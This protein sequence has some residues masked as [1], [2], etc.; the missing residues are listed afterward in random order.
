MAD[1]IALPQW[2]EASDCQIEA[3]DLGTIKTVLTQKGV[4]ARGWRLY[5]DHGDVL[6]SPLVRHWF[7]TYGSSQ[8]AT[9]ATNWLRLLQACEMDVL[10][11]PELVASI[12]QWRLPGDRLEAIPPLFFR[13][14]WKSC[15]AA[16]YTDEGMED[17][18]KAQLIPL[19]QWFFGS[20]AHQSDDTGRLKAGWESIKRLRHESVAAMAQK[21]GVD[22]W[23]PILRKFEAGAYRMLALT[24]ECQLMEEGEEM[25]HCVG[26]YADNCRYSPLRIFSVRYKKT[27][28]RVAT[29]SIKEASPGSWTIDQL[30]GPENAE[31]DPLLW[32]EA[33]ALL[34]FANRISRND[35]QIRAFFDFIHSLGNK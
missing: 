13:A 32:R 16:Q 20:G 10:P 33:D 31:V 1:H 18:I 4:N 9:V 6:F 7:A 28:T 34:E 21:L 29:L 30:K 5:L 14:A 3:D 19:A 26:T 23:P 8:K 2:L 12:A 15:V 27:D 17:F 22:E 35:A 24:S 11:P 25:G